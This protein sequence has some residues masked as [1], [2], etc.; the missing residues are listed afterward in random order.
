MS[1]RQQTHTQVKHT[2]AGATSRVFDSL[3]AV[4]EHLWEVTMSCW[5]RSRGGPQGCSE[6]WSTSPMETGWELGLFSL[7]KEGSGE[8]SLWPSST[9]RELVSRRGGWLLTQSDSDRTRGNG[10]KVKEGLFRLDVKKKIF[11]EGAM[12]PRHCCP[13]KLWMPHPWRWSVPGW[14]GRQAL[15]WWV[16]TSPRQGNGAQCSLRSLPT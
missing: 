6:G 11:T 8:T 10:F 3:G 5:S 1:E 9:W 2:A 12:R 15:I 13:E 4:H 14:M 7:E 16:A